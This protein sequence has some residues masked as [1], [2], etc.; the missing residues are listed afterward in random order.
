MAYSIVPKRLVAVELRLA[1]RARARRISASNNR[2]VV[3]PPSMSAPRPSAR[4][5]RRF[6]FHADTCHVRRLVDLDQTGQAQGEQKGAATSVAA[7]TKPPP[8]AAAPTRRVGAAAGVYFAM[9]FAVGLALGPVRVLW[10]EPLLGPT[11]AVLCE[12]PL[13]ILAMS[14]ASRLAPRWVGMSGG[15]A[16][17][18]AMGVLAL[19]LQQAADLAARLPGCAA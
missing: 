18:L 13:L 1:R 16:A 8:R 7:E 4:R 2:H 14:I 15:W 6:I 3:A 5:A 19:A 12:A 17:Y 9:V 10:L 11:I